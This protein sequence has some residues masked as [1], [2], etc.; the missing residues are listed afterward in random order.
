VKSRQTASS[1][2]ENSGEVDIPATQSQKPVQS[3]D[4]RILS[5]VDIVT[6]SSQEISAI[7]RRLSNMFNALVESPSRCAQLNLRNAT[8]GKSIA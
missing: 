4:I 6:L 3:L 5:P 8:F 1:N 7:G 2:K